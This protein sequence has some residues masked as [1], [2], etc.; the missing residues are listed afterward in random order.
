MGRR[1]GGEEEE[2]EEEDRAIMFHDAIGPRLSWGLSWE[3]L[4]EMRAAVAGLQ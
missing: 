4:D 3:D 2:E 1:Q